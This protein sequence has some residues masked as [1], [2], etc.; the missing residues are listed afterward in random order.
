LYARD[1]EDSESLDI[2][3]RV[4]AKLINVG[5]LRRIEYIP[6][7]LPKIFTMRTEL[8]AKFIQHL[9]R[10]QSEKGFTLVELLVVIIIIGILAAIALPNFLNQASKAK[11]SEGKQNVALTNK[12]QNSYRAENSNFAS[13]FDILAIGSVVDSNTGTGSTSNFTYTIPTAGSEYTSVIASPKDLA[14]KGYSG[15]AS[16]FANAASQSIIATV[17]CENR[18]VGTLTPMVAP[19]AAGTT[20]TPTGVSTCGATTKTISLN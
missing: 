14:L 13:S 4:I 16:R 11:Q 2:F 1:T 5:K 18:T 6:Q 8:K 3:D 7:P 12:T 10:K 17:M 20:T 19:S 15:A 9:N